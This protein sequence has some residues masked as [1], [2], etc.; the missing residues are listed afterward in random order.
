MIESAVKNLYGRWENFPEDAVSFIH[1]II[2][3][4]DY[5]SLYEQTRHDENR[6]KEIL[7]DFQKD[8]PGVLNDENTNVILNERAKQASKASLLDKLKKEKEALQS[9]Q[10]SQNEIEGN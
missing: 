4:K 2:Q 6:S 5:V 10:K 9:R 8:Y 1:G 3:E 7:L